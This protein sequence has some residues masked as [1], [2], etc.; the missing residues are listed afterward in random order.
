MDTVKIQKQN[1]K[2]IAHRGVSGLETENTCPAFVAAGNRSY[3]GVETDV[4][5]TSDGR[6]VIIH[7][8]W[9]GRVSR[10]HINVNV[11]ETVFSEIA[12]IALADIDGSFGRRDISI[13]SLDDYISICRKYEKTCVLEL[14]NHFDPDV[15]RT[16]LSEIEATG[17]LS[18]IIFISFDLDN[19]VNLRKFLPDQPIQWLLCAPITDEIFSILKENRLDLDSC[20]SYLSKEIVDRLHAQGTLVNCWTVDDPN[21]G[22]NLV[23]MGVDFIT[24]NI[25]E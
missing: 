17:W 6:F 5:V 4:H 13:P 22:E 11:E 10:G 24:T 16:M 8:E 20:F 9:T 23:R 12:S 2:M 7:D 14:K 25:L 1:V 19:V 15:I 3:F 21:D 18:H